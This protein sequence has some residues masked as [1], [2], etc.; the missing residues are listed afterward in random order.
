V[1]LYLL[2]P[3]FSLVHRVLLS[4]VSLALRAL[5]P[6]KTLFPE[7]VFYDRGLLFTRHRV[8]FLQVIKDWGQLLGLSDLYTVGGKEEA[9][10]M[11]DQLRLDTLDS[12]WDTFSRMS[13]TKLVAELVG[14]RRNFYEVSLTASRLSRL[15]L[16]VFLL[17]V[18]GSLA[19]SYLRSRACTVCGVNFTFEHFASCSALGQ[20]LLPLLSLARESE[21]WEQFILLIVSRF[22]VFLHFHRGGIC[23]QDETDLFTALDDMCVK[24]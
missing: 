17:A 23:D 20:D 16:R 9:A 1:T 24:R 5:R 2:F 21:D 12:T 3:H 10:G 7:A 11:L 13:S 8:G 19:Q 14:N 6:L 15:G 18:T 4:K 22:Q